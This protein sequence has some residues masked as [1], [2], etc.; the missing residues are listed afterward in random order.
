MPWTVGWKAHQSRAVSLLGPLP[1]RRGGGGG[2]AKCGRRATSLTWEQCVFGHSF[3]G[4][5]SLFSLPK[6]ACLS[7]GRSRS[8]NKESALALFPRTHYHKFGPGCMLNLLHIRLTF[9][10]VPY[11]LLAVGPSWNG[12]AHKF[13]LGDV[14]FRPFLH[15]P[16]F[17]LGIYE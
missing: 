1:E 4:C 9:A 7:L 5:L 8:R 10:G 11:L 13:A 14:Y 16:F 2:F 17:V 15:F 12:L 6:G 3:C